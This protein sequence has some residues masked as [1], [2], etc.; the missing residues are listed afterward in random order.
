MQAI[1]VQLRRFSAVQWTFIG[2]LLLSWIAVSYAG[3]VA[4]DAAFYLDL[5]QHFIDHGLA[6]TFSRFNWPWF[7]VLLGITNIFTGIPLE[8]AAYLWC[9]LFMAGT[10]A[11]LVDGISRRLPGCA[12]WACLV[13]LAM[14]AYNNFRDDILREY[15]F[16]FFC[17][18]ALWF[19][20]R[21]EER[22]GW[23]RALLIHLSILLAALFR[24][25]AVLLMPA[26][27]LWQICGMRT[28]AGAIR[29]AQ[30]VALPVLVTVVAGAGLLLFDR[31]P[32]GRIEYYLHLIDPRSLFATFSSVAERFGA[33]ILQKYS[34]D[35]AGTILF[36]GFL[37]TLLLTFAKLLGPFS[38]PFLFREGWLAI[39]TFRQKFA[40]FAW[41]WLCYF[42]VLMFFFIQ[43]QFING[44]YTSF[45]N[46]L[47][48]PLVVIALV[49]LARRFPRGIKAL[50]V[51]A[52]L[53]MLANVIS[54][55]AK[56]THYIE[57]GQWLSQH[58]QPTDAIF[59]DDSRIGYYAGWGYQLPNISR[60]QAMSDSRV[61]D[62]RYYLI[63][64]KA[65]EAWLQ[66]WLQQH[67]RQILAEFANAKGATVLVIGE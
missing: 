50:V 21:W 43:Q 17:I 8:T 53:V 55:S 4:K 46:M 13:V 41:A 40:I 54:L 32:L 23:G 60:G 2:S 58:A 12:Y 19:A 6:D 39:G 65:D 35:D 67:H 7:S 28:R 10:C 42:A 57:A 9:A 66:Q 14:P 61:S 31:L 38:V 5:A 44:R 45:L 51:V 1:T 36:F 59:Y 3:T 30:L 11:L 24:L 29:M 52:L 20:L 37:A 22:G 48:V 16:W 63:E 33:T 64:A 25:E 34:A 49:A 26:L 27:V 18:L 62:Y 47:A 56:K 15:G